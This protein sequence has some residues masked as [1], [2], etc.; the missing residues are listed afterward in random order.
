[1][2]ARLLECINKT[3]SKV[4]LLFRAQVTPRRTTDCLPKRQP[5]ERAWQQCTSVAPQCSIAPLVGQQH[6]VSFSLPP[7]VLDTLPLECLGTGIGQGDRS[8]AIHPGSLSSGPCL[9]HTH[10]D[11]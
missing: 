11:T 9:A 6:E 8:L 3:S 1:M 5:A 10:V 2:I 4:Q 7:D